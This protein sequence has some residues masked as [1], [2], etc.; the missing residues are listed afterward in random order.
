[1][2]R[3]TDFTLYWE[4][5]GG[6]PERKEPISLPELTWFIATA[7]S[8][9]RCLVR[10]HAEGGTITWSAQWQRL[11]REL[12][13]PVPGLLEEA[14]AFDEP[15]P[16]LEDITEGPYIEVWELT[17]ALHDRPF[18]LVVQRTE[19]GQ[20]PPLTLGRRL[21]DSLSSLYTYQPGHDR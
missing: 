19:P 2:G 14:G 10:A 12:L 15:V 4:R 21:S 3:Y 18:R 17:G 1:V 5:W 11:P 8:A 16:L 6:Y 20:W 9:M 7:D 13:D